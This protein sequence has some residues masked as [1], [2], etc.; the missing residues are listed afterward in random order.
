M[1]E[2]Q[3]LELSVPAQACNGIVFYLY[4]YRTEKTLYHWAKY[5]QVQD[6]IITLRLRAVNRNER[7]LLLPIAKNSG[8]LNSAPE[9]FA[10]YPSAV[11][12]G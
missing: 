8:D 1:R 7:H 2:L 12:C 4:L 6:F 9:T 3:P 10:V 11:R 5:S